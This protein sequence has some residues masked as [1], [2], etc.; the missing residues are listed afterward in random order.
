MVSLGFGCYFFGSARGRCNVYT[1]PQVYGMPIPPRGAA[2]A[3]STFPLSSPPTQ[4]SKPS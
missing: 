1:N 4:Y 3:N 2:I